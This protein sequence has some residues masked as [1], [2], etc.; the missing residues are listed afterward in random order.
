MKK[1]F[2]GIL[3]LFAFT[4]CRKTKD[5]HLPSGSQNQSTGTAAVTA[6]GI[7]T[8][9]A[10]QK[11]IGAAGGTIVSA[12][13][14][15]MFTV[16]A[17]AL[18]ADEIIS[19]QSI[20]NKAPLGIKNRAYRFLPHGLQFKKP[21]TLTLVYDENDIAGSTPEQVS[22]ASQ[23]E[24]G[25]WK[26]NGTMQVNL[27]NRTMT[28]T[29]SHF[30]DYAFYESFKMVDAK[31]DSDTSVLELRTS[32][33]VKL[34]V[35][36]VKEISLDD[37][38][39]LVIS[40]PLLATGYVKEW[41][42]N[43]QTHPHPD[44]NF[45]GLGGKNGYTIAERDYI[46][47]RRAP[48]PNSITVTVKLDLGSKGVLFLLRNV[49]ITDA[50]ILG[51]NGKI[52]NG[53]MPSAIYLNNN[54][55]L[56]FGILKLFPNGKSASVGVDIEDIASTV[57][58]VYNFSASEKVKILAHDELNNHWSSSKTNPLTGVTTHS[59][60]IEITV[61]GS[62]NSRQLFIKITGMLFGTGPTTNSAPVNTIIDVS[63]PVF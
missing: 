3:L 54:T 61:S 16:P 34:T 18:D 39:E 48:S 6:V 12:D 41:T 20:E 57:P 26:K 4:A 14:K 33:E 22:L 62:G 50:N 51:L 19:V 31:T 58:G 43:G 28:T 1:V 49:S 42:V 13:G 52:Y 24:K 60:N 17:G 5:D 27:N 53:A 38:N 8:G 30:S 36:Y 21:A 40:V 2:Y 15:I 29:I 45:G 11:T 25:N 10:V 56:N 9:T 63:A 7:P 59:G 35:Y 44:L 55:W 23:T 47:P 32:E 46:A 37:A